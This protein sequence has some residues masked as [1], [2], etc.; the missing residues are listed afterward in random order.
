MACLARDGIKGKG[1]R[2]KGKKLSVT[3]RFAV[4]AVIARDAGLDET[5]AVG[6]RKR[7]AIMARMRDE[8]NGHLGKL[9]R[10]RLAEVTSYGFSYQR[11]QGIFVHDSSL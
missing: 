7:V 8:R 1:K 3:V 11:P 9:G 2:E 4:A 6:W 10:R 5:R